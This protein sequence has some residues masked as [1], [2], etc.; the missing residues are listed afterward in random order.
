LIVRS[1]VAVVLSSSAFVRAKITPDM[2]LDLPFATGTVTNYLSEPP[3]YLVTVNRKT[4]F[5]TTPVCA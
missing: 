5:M 2:I 1:L 3:Y 4:E